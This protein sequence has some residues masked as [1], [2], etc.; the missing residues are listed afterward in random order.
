[1]KEDTKCNIK[2]GENN[3]SV[4]LKIFQW[5]C[6]F[7]DKVKFRWATRGFIIVKE[8]VSPGHSIRPSLYAQFS[9]LV[10]FSG[11]QLKNNSIRDEFNYNY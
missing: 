10:K 9:F 11:F 5:V 2:K 7:V 3:Q 6:S 1:M 8:R 4:F